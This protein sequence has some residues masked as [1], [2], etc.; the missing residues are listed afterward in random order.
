MIRRV[1][2]RKYIPR[3][4][5]FGRKF[6]QRTAMNK[7]PF[8]VKRSEKTILGALTSPDCIVLLAEHEGQITGVLIGAICSYPFF[9]ASYATDLVF[10]AERDGEK[11]FRQFALWA[12]KHGVDVLQMGVT[13]GLEVADK[14]YAGIGMK[15]VGGIYIQSLKEDTKCPA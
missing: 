4:I 7:L 1:F 12:L 2:D 10:I 13:S 8:S 11:L 3:I 15:S 14:F 5:A 6:H 9:E